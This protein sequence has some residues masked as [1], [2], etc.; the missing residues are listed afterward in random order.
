M[1][2]IPR[3]EKYQQLIVK[4]KRVDG[5][6]VD[7]LRPLK[8]ELGVIKRATGSAYVELGKTK[9]YAAVYG[10]RELHPKR[11]I[12]EDR[13]VLNVR[14]AMTPFSVIDRQR[15]GPNRRAIEIS[16][17]ARHALEP[18]IFLEEYPQLSIDLILDV[19]Q[20]DA[21]TRV[22]AINAAS[23]A[24]AHAGV[25]MRGL[26][27]AC[28]AGKVDGQMVLDLCGPEDNYGEADIPIAMASHSKNLTLLQ[29]DGKVTR[30]EFK[31]AVEM[32]KKGC[33]NILKA[34]ENALR[35]YYQ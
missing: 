28:A 32:A 8:I 20:A 11:L 21:G 9:V 25:F 27:A 24:L 19:V 17:V 26:V 14:Y 12:N 34:Q 2:G 15:P 6:K 22:T 35:G 4:G 7:E 3:P 5:R 33:E 18:V 1:S 13:A 30:E 16:K 23:V 29:L 31:K 10:P